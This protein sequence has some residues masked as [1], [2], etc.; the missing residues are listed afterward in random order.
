V[1]VEF[2]RREQ[3]RQAPLDASYGRSLRRGDGSRGAQQ[4][5][6]PEARDSDVIRG[7]DDSPRSERRTCF[8]A[9][10]YTY[11]YVNRFL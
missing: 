10:L 7:G 4:R 5:W 3:R 1:A 6:P 8:Y 2:R 11:L 9:T